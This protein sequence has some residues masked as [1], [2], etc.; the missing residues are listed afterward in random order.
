[1]A[2]MA[3]AVSGMS[4]VCHKEGTEPWCDPFARNQAASMGDER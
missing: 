2:A 1:M 4:V 3:S